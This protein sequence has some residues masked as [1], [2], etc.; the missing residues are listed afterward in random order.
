[1]APGITASTLKAV[2][3]GL[4]AEYT[5]TPK[6]TAAGKATSMAAKP[7]RK[8]PEWRIHVP[9][10]RASDWLRNK[11]SFIAARAAPIH[12][13]LLDAMLWKTAYNLALGL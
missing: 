7:P 10:K 9:E 6:A 3:C 4:I 8:S 11:F 5:V 2:Y 13:R 12:Q 1:M